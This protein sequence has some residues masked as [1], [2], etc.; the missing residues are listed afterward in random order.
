MEFP[1]QLW[2]PFEFLSRDLGMSLSGTVYNLYYCNVVRDADHGQFDRFRFSF[3]DQSRMPAIHATEVNKQTMLVEMAAAGKKLFENMIGCMRCVEGGHE[4]EAIV[5]LRAVRE[6]SCTIYKLFTHWMQDE[7]IAYEYWMRY[8]QGPGGWGIDGEDGLTGAHT[9]AI[10]AMDAFLGI[11]GTSSTW[12]FTLK[13][14]SHMT[15]TM[16]SFLEKLEGFDLIGYVKK[17]EGQWTQNEAFRDEYE[18]CV[19]RLRGFRIAHKYRVLPYFGIHAPE[20]QPMTAGG[21]LVTEERYN[22]A[23]TNE[24]S[25]HDEFSAF[26]RARLGERIAETVS[27]LAVSQESGRGLP[28]LQSVVVASVA[29]SV[30][31]SFISSGFN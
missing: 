22:Q 17:N 25:S 3:I 28:L 9:L 29:I 8:V 12:A 10:P 6:L 27:P 4:R 11:Q 20:R 1:E 18:L 16:R 31:V 14:R 19:R 26:F 5:F 23:L 30:A 21:G 15:A 7:Y 24:T 2:K 13:H